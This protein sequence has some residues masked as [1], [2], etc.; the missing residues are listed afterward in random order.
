MA[1]CSNLHDRHEPMTLLD[2][3]LSASHPD[4][5]APRSKDGSRR[6]SWLDVVRAVALLRVLLWHTLGW[7]ALTYL[8]ASIPTMFFVSGSLLAKSTDRR[9]VGPVLRDRLQR[10]L[11]PFWAFGAF[12]W[13]VLAVGAWRSQTPLPL[14]R[15][16][17]WV[18]PLGDP[19]GSVWS[20]G[21]LSSHL[22]Y[23]RAFVWLLL[24]TPLL[25]RLVRRA[26]RLTIAA[27]AAGVVLL[28]VLGRRSDWPVHG[29]VQWMV[30]DVVLYGTFL[31]AGMAHRDGYFE[32]KP[33]SRW[34]KQALVF[35]AAA[36]AWRVTQPLPTNIV[37]DSHPL[38]LFVGAAWLSAALAARQSIERFGRGRARRAIRLLSRRSLTIYLWHP[39]AIVVAVA[40]L[41]RTE[42]TGPARTAALLGGVVVLTAVAAVMTGPLE[43]LAAGRRP[44]HARRSQ[45]LT[46]GIRRWTI[47]TVPALAA[48]L[49]VITPGMTLAV[50]QGT[51]RPPI[52]SLQPTTP[53]FE[54]GTTAG[55]GTADAAALRASMDDLFS[56]W[57]E[58][59]GIEGAQVGLGVG[60]DLTWSAAAGVRA[61]GTAV[62]VGDTID[63]ASITKL[64]TAEMVYA[65]AEDGLIDLDTPLPRIDALPTFP[66]DEGITPAQLLSH[67]SGLREFREAAA[68]KNDPRHNSTPATAVAAA[69]GLGRVGAPGEVHLYASTN[70]LVL[71]LL[72]EQATG[73]TYD[74]LVRA[75]VLQPLG[76]RETRHLTSYA[77]APNGGAAGLQTTLPEL[78]KLGQGILR[79]HVGISAASAARMAD[80]DTTNGFGGGALGYC[81]CRVDAEGNR[82]FFAIG[83]T[84]GTS[85]VVWAP[86]L[87]LTIAVDLSQS[88]WAEH[89]AEAVLELVRRI[90][91]VATSS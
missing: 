84:G 45:L 70:Y 91:R 8:V 57:M 19:A 53:T 64:A 11:L 44:L 35:G 15:L 52:P 25:R 46:G 2:A 21:W 77:G 43:D 16:A 56:A 71:G 74:Q 83:H 5:A 32:G 17:W 48:L 66:Y 76:L 61:D 10:I 47:L 12:V 39:A 6:E 1:S 38:H 7:A 68:F 67:T 86:S 3:P 88:L 62:A 14:R 80:I 31:V 85:Y 34:W 4:A 9:G 78:V 50:A 20:D 18:L 89:R 28:D 41:D 24:L 72:L 60:D 49:V 90:E 29:D 79:D 87:D 54:E 63:L 27:G 51:K 13:G 55:R 81:P 75:E 36:V 37:N 33:A 69:L 23:V 65:A 59:T 82:S 73:R 22:W 40:V 42:L 58:D 26:P 30:G